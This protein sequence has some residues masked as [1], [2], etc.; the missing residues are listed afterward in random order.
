MRYYSSEYRRWLKNSVKDVSDSVESHGYKQNIE[1]VQAFTHNQSNCKLQCRSAAEYAQTQMSIVKTKFDILSSMLDNFYNDASSVSSSVSSSAKRINEII[2]EANASLIRIND[3]LKG[4]GQYQ[5]EVLSQENLQSAGIDKAKCDTLKKDT[6]KKILVTEKSYKCIHDTIARN[7]VERVIG[8]YN[9]GKELSNDDA[10]FMDAMSAQFLKSLKWNNIADRVKDTRLLSD[11]FKY[12]KDHRLGTTGNT[13][14]LPAETLE[15]V[16]DIYETI[17]PKAKL[18]TDNFLQPCYEITNKNA[19]NAVRNAMLIKHDLYTADPRLRN[20]ILSCLPHMVLEN[21][22]LSQIACC[23]GNTLRL[24]LE[25][26]PLNSL[27]RCAA[28][29]HEFGHAMDNIALDDYEENGRKIDCLSDAYYDTLIADAT[30]S[31][32]KTIKDLGYENMETELIEFIISPENVNV[33]TD[34]NSD[35]YTTL[36]PKDWS[37]EMKD[38]FKAI[39]DYYGY[40]EYTYQSTGAFSYT[41]KAYDGKICDRTPESSIINDILGAITNN[42]VAAVSNAHVP[43]EKY[44]YMQNGLPRTRE[45]IKG[46]DDLYKGLTEGSYWVRHNKDNPWMT[47]DIFCTEFF[48][49]SF[50]DRIYGIDQTKTREV[51]PNGIDMFEDDLN[52]LIEHKDQLFSY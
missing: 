6:W 11:L 13:H 32:Q 12:Y 34:S 29:F 27:D 20:L 1:C 18:I 23:S 9:N 14:D 30:H 28:F 17:N 21:Q 43:N 42:Q 45:D 46:P 52:M 16:A 37:P 3:A 40:Y 35:Y 33:A 22:P 50:D 36:L 47:S 15:V 8:E 5:G 25:E 26:N 2:N 19:E 7:F 51:F 4:V 38:A 24:H 49:E 39:R 31:L 10:D 44:P 48:A 41:A